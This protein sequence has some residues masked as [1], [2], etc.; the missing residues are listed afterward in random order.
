MKKILLIIF[1]LL[2]S[3][4]KVQSDYRYEDDINIYHY[5]AQE[6]DDGI[7]YY[8]ILKRENGLIFISIESF[9]KIT[10]NNVTE[11]Q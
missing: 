5:V 9:S 3:C 8:K 10:E 1:T 4:V 6:T 7:R 11:A 2:S